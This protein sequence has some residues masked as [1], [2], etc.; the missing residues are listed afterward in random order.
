MSGICAPLQTGGFATY[1]AQVDSFNKALQRNTTTGKLTALFKT[2]MLS[3]TNTGCSSPGRSPNA[4]AG[5]A[6]GSC[7][8]ADEMLQWSNV[9]EAGAAK[10]ASVT[11]WTELVCS[12]DQP[13]R[14]QCSCAAN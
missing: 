13:H 9:S 8:S 4:S 2:K 7:L 12:F 14:Q 10:D 3:R 1:L 5:G 6:P 11:A